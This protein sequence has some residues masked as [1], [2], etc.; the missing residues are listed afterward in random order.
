MK[1]KPLDRRKSLLINQ[2]DMSRENTIVN[3]EEQSTLAI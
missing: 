3:L 1:K 2:Y